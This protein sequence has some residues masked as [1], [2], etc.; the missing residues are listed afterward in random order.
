MAGRQ[1]AHVPAGV[2]HGPARVRHVMAAGCSVQRGAGKHGR[3]R[4]QW[5]L[6]GVSPHQ[7]RSQGEGEGGGL[8]VRRTEGGC[9]GSRPQWRKGASTHGR[10]RMVTR[11]Q[12]CE[13]PLKCV[14]EVP[15]KWSMHDTP[16]KRRAHAIN[17]F[18][19][20]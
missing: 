9:H 18:S 3:G 6:D 16:I 13:P 7:R 4:R 1:Q 15:I 14:V 11:S 5:R 2:A 8:Q 19:K 12:A 17:F 10:G 20:F